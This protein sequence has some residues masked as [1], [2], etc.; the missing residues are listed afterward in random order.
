MLNLNI[1]TDAYLTQSLPSIPCQINLPKWPLLTLY[2]KL[3][4]QPVDLAIPASIPKVSELLGSISEIHRWVHDNIG[5]ANRSYKVRVNGSRRSQSFM[6]GD[7]V[8]VH[9]RKGRFPQG[10]Y[11]KLRVEISGPAKL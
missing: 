9:L 3:P 5:S 8:M 2:G 4:A 7:F 1:G 10:G 11:S 6:E